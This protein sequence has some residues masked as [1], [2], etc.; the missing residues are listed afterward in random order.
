MSLNISSATRAGRENLLPTLNGICDEL[1]E[2]NNYM[3][4]ESFIFYVFVELGSQHGLDEMN[5]I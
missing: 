3:F 1:S 2:F 4:I 5:T